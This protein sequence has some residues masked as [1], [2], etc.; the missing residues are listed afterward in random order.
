MWETW[1]RT[2]T[3]LPEDQLAI[4]QHLGDEAPF[5]VEDDDQDVEV[6]DA[7]EDGQ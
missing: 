4:A 6:I 2:D 1:A 3:Q 7:G 5:V